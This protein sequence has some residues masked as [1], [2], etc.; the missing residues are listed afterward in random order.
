MN[1][2]VILLYSINDIHA[3]GV[4]RG[5]NMS[6]RTAGKENKRT[7]VLPVSDNRNVNR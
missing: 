3:A 5:E 7:P 2:V 1:I 6:R 4:P